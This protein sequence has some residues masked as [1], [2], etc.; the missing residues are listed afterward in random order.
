MRKDKEKKAIEICLYERQRILN[1][2]FEWTEEAKAGI[3]KLNTALIEANKLVNEEYDK[4]KSE[5]EARE[6]S[7]DKFLTD[8]NIDKRIGLMIKTLDENGEWEEPEG[9]I[10]YIL[11]D[12]ID[13]DSFHTQFIAT[14]GDEDNG[15]PSNWNDFGN[16]SEISKHF[17]D[18][19]IHY[20]IYC[21]CHN[22]PLAWEDILKIRSLWTE[23]NVDY[24]RITNLF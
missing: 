23:V 3:L 20:G 16:P 7:D 24:Q 10:Y 21:L 22:T 4:L 8:Y 17:K 12:Y 11:N 1:E 9:G 18:D 13:C 14:M 15:S 5:L 2:K 19:F 6:K